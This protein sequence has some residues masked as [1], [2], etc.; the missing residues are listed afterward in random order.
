M[1]SFA[2]GTPAGEGTTSVSPGGLPARVGYATRAKLTGG[3]SHGKTAT[4]RSPQLVRVRV[5]LF[6][7][8]FFFSFSLLFVTFFVTFFFFIHSILRRAEG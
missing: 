5:C 2:L 6:F 1:F 4:V 7:H 8:F 3:I